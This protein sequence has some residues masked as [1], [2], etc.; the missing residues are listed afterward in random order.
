MTLVHQLWGS[1]AFRRSTTA[2]FALP[3]PQRVTVLWPLRLGQ[4]PLGPCNSTW[5]LQNMMLI[6]SKC[7]KSYGELDTSGSS[8]PQHLGTEASQSLGQNTG[9][10][11]VI[12]MDLLYMAY[13]LRCFSLIPNTSLWMSIILPIVIKPLS[14]FLENQN[15][16]AFS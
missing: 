4:S 3:S 2:N 10:S 7:T 16:L 15:L 8:S 14:C 5:Y 6:S 1:G 12:Y 13:L 9:P 11:K